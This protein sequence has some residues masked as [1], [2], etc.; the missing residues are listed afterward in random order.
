MPDTPQ[1]RAPY[2]IL[3][4]GSRSWTDWSTV[5]TALE[6]AIEQ[7]H[8]QGH[9][10]YVIVHGGAQGADRIAADFCEDQAG[11]YDNADQTLAVEHHPADWATCA[12]TCRPGHRRARRDGTTYCPT[13]G[14]RRDAAMVALGANVCIAFIDPCTKP[15]C[16]KIKPHGSHGASHT[17][18][19]AENAGILVRRLEEKVHA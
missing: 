12:P 11:W 4:T 6:D 8:Q 18:D 14:L 5:W 7:A 10:E 2:R 13:A 17:A 3:V 9:R 19:L 15:G 16:R 1:T